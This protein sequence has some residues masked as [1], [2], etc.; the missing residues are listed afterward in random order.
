MPQRYPTEISERILALIGHFQMS[1]FVE[2]DGVL[3]VPQV[4]RAV[5]LILDAL[6]LLRCRFVEH[7]W[8]PRWEENPEITAERI[9]T[10]E[11][12]GDPEQRF[13]DFLARPPDHPWQVMVHK[14]TR[15]ALA[16]KLDHGLADYRA[17]T[18]L[19]YL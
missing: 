14:D 15:G 19:V 2:L 7:W 18:Q 13:F 4:V 16:V 9:V 17:L 11:K 6:P 3:N 12:D 10:I 8:Q 1:L 5:Q